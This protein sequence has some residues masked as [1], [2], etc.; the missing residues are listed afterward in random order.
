MERCHSVTDRKDN[1]NW[2]DQNDDVETKTILGFI[3]TDL[4]G[5]TYNDD[6]ILT[7]THIGIYKCGWKKFLRIL[8]LK[9]TF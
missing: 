7:Y 8:G 2:V 5:L 3:G 1:D 9:N 6:D 4:S